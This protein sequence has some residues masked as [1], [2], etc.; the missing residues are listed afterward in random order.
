[1]IEAGQADEIAFMKEWLT[2]RGA[3]IADPALAGHGAHL[4][5]MMAGMASPEEMK[6]LAAAKGADFDRMFLSLM[7]AHHEG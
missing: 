4:H 5:H 3:P 2:K 1:R 6:A 7:I